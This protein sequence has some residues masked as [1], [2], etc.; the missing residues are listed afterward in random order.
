MKPNYFRI[1]FKFVIATPFC[2]S[3]AFAQSGGTYQITQSAVAGGGATTSAAGQYSLGGTVGQ[4]QAGTLTP[5]G[6]YALQLGF[7]TS[8]A[9][10]PT[11]AL[12]SI[13]GR[14]VTADGSG[15]RSVV[16]TLTDSSGAVRVVRTGTFGNYHFDNVAA[17]ESYVLTIK[18][19]KYVFS[20]ATRIISV[21][22]NLGDVDFTADNQAY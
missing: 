11:A 8:A 6:T 10:A 16:L 2:L 18:S 9:L 14:V 21:T 19:R 7:W 22:D 15:I 5:N 4:A 17:G 13:S 12:V 20:S 3:V 1:L